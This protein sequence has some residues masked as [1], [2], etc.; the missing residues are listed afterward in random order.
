[1][2]DFTLRRLGGTTGPFC[3]NIHDSDWRLVGKIFL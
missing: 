2:T 3:V 1:M